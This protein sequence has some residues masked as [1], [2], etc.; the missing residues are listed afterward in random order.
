M[1][2]MWP[3]M[4]LGGLTRPYVVDTHSYMKKSCALRTKTLPYDFLLPGMENI[5]KISIALTSPFP[6]KENLPILRIQGSFPP[7]Y[8][9]QFSSF[10]RCVENPQLSHY[11]VLRDFSFTNLTFGGSLVS[12]TLVPSVWFLFS[13]FPGIHQCDPELS[14]H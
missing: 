13:Y 9:Q 2:P 6:Y 14:N 10:L 3:C 11:K 4:A 7:L 8:K 1:T 5:P 12:T